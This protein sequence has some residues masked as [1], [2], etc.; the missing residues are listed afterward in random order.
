MSFASL[1]VIRNK[2]TY[3]YLVNWLHTLFIN[4]GGVIFIIL[5]LIMNVIIVVTAIPWIALT[6][7][8]MRDAGLNTASA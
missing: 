3:H 7:R 1:G 2:G 8:R 5:T 4:L 6:I